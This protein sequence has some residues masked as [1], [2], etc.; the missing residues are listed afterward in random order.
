MQV[1]DTRVY[2]VKAVADM[3]DVS[4]AT[5][6]RAI[7]SG[8]LDAY[9]FGSGKGTLRV[10][11]HAIRIYLDGCAQTTDD[12]GQAAAASTVAR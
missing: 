5:I 7:E 4:P 12:Q 8:E 1:D 6:Y 3:L 9:K 2:R 11:G 10:P